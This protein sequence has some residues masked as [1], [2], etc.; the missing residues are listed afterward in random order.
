MFDP[1]LQAQASDPDRIV[2][3]WKD[4]LTQATFQGWQAGIILV[5]VHVL[6]KEPA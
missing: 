2:V 4:F 5:D 3:D 6:V 1:F